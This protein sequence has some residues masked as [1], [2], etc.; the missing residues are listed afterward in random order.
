MAIDMDA[1][2]AAAYN[3]RGVALGSMG[4]IM[5]AISDFE[6]AIALAPD[7]LGAYKNLSMAYSKIGDK[8]RA[9]ELLERAPRKR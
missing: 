3:N 1:N 8:A 5:S 9:A 4:E 2:D 7:F 6:R